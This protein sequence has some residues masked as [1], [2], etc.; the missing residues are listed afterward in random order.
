LTGK[1]AQNPKVWVVSTLFV[2]L[3]GKLTRNVW[4]LQNRFPLVSYHISPNFKWKYGEEIY[5]RFCQL[6]IS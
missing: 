6:F 1:T 2:S 3:K 4:K 5:G